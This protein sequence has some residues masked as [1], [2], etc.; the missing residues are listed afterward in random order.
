MQKILTFKAPVTK[1]ASGSKTT[2]VK[3]PGEIPQQ[4]SDAIFLAMLNKLTLDE[5][6][7]LKGYIA[8]MIVRV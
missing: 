4:Y 2:T 8:G 6:V 1:A 5:R 7:E 3:K